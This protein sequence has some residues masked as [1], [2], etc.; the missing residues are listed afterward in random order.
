MELLLESIA[1]GYRSTDACRTEDA[2]NPMR[3]GSDFR[4]LI[5]DLD[6]PDDPFARAER[7]PDKGQAQTVREPPSLNDMVW[8]IRPTRQ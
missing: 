5:M 4:L 8:H 2:L 3:G 7:G 6:M 1:K